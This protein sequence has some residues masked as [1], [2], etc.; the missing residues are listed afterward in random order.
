MVT[1]EITNEKSTI[2]VGDKLEMSVTLDLNSLTNI[3]NQ[4]MHIEIILRELHKK[5]YAFC[6]LLLKLQRSVQTSIFPILDTLFMLSLMIQEPTS[7]TLL[8]TV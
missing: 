1:D 5:D 7:L 4:S 2:P 3:I 8:K 6:L